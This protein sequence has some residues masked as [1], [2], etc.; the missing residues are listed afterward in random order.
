MLEAKAVGWSKENREIKI[1][2]VIWH[3]LSGI[4]KQEEFQWYKV[5]LP[6]SQELRERHFS[7]ESNVAYGVNEISCQYCHVLRKEHQYRTGTIANQSAAFSSRFLSRPPWQSNNS[8]LS[9]YSLTP[10]TIVGYYVTG[11]QRLKL[12]RCVDCQH[13]GRR[14]SQS[15]ITSPL[16]STPP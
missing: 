14:P 3:W 4:S 8:I 16:P 5:F 7:T 10:N 2:M 11:K 9:S 1:F 13:R 12:D 15:R 6:G